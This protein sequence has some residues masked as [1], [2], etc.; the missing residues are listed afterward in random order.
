MAV[1]NGRIR[2]LVT[3]VRVWSACAAGGMGKS[4]TNGKYF[5]LDRFSRFRI[6]RFACV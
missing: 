1:M 4:M 6:F 2:T 5:H 3:F